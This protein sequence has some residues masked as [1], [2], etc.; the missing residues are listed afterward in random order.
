[1][2][3]SRRLASLAG[4]LKLI[5][6]SYDD[7][8]WSKKGKKIGYACH[9]DIYDISKDGK[10]IIVCARQVEGTKYGQKTISK[11][12]YRVKK[13]YSKC[14]VSSTEKSLVAKLAKISTEVGSVIRSL[15]KGVTYKAPANIKRIGYKLVRQTETGELESVWDQS[16]WTLGKTRV[17]KSSGDF[18]SGLYCYLTKDDA[19][20]AAANNSVFGEARSH[21]DLVLIECEISGKTESVTITKKC[22]SRIK[23]LRI[24]Q[25]AA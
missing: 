9:H 10:E 20:R 19:L 25:K 7:M 13:H 12:Y 17:E 24:L 18:S 1:M 6:S 15:D 22:V 4:R 23:P 2:A 11:T 5:Y 3:S 16:P 14:V 21:H 8:E